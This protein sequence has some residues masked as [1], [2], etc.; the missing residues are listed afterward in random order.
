M[1][2]HYRQQEFRFGLAKICQA[3]LF[4]H[5]TG[6]FLLI[7]GPLRFIKYNNMLGGNVVVSSILV[8]E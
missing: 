8:A 1:P 2:V 7:P 3:S 6:R 4:S 5:E